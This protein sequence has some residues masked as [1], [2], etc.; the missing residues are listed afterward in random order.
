VRDGHEIES[1]LA[2]VAI[3]Y[4]AYNFCKMHTSLRVT[5]AMAAGATTRVTT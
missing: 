1:H 3:N 5:P 2:A 4:F